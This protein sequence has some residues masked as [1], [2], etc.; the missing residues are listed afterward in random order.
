M[1]L[2]PMQME[3]IILQPY[4]KQYISLNV[5]SELLNRRV[6]SLRQQHLSALEKKK[7]LLLA[8]PNQRTHNKQA[9]Y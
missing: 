7:T 3:E 2:S 4:S 5:L 9:Y 8:Y 6:D 1:R